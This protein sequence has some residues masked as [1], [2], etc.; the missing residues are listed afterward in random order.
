MGI[1]VLCSKYSMYWEKSL[2][3]LI[4]R[5]MLFY[6]ISTIVLFILPQSIYYKIYNILFNKIVFGGISAGLTIHYSTNG[7]YIS[8]GMCMYFTMYINEIKNKK[9]KKYFY[10]F[11]ICI[12]ALL[13][14]GKRG[15][16]L[17]A[18]FACFLIFIIT[19]RG[20]LNGRTVK[21]VYIIVILGILLLALS[22]LFQN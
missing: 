8:M 3:N 9:R 10:A 19:S 14:T 20:K 5:M 11:F 15:P 18:I 21:I 13:M 4:P 2:L 7:M 12:S 6:S 17:A 1:F 22:F 16:L